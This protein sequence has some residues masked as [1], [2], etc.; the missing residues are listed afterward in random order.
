MYQNIT[1]REI[2]FSGNCIV[3]DDI[4]FD[5]NHISIINPLVSYYKEQASFSFFIKKTGNKTSP[6]KAGI[7]CRP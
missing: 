1:A 6:F 5:I 7:H 3:I 2:T 4:Y